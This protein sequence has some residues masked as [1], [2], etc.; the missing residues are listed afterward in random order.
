MFGFVFVVCTNI[1]DPVT[2]IGQI[3]AGFG[4]HLQSLTGVEAMTEIMGKS[5]K[6]K[7][8][9]YLI[10]KLRIIRGVEYRESE[11]LTRVTGTA[12]IN[13]SNDLG[14]EILLLSINRS[15]KTLSQ[16]YFMK[17]IKTFDDRC[18][19]KFL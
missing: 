6:I 7:H 13:K 16:P 11:I 2:L 14:Y 18:E 3:C 10:G 8:F 9:Q 4:S 19:S 1:E 17:S 12:V 15:Y 5:E